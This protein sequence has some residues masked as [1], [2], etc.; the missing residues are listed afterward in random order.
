M[1]N[2]LLSE[3]DGTKELESHLES[4]NQDI[5]KLKDREKHKTRIERDAKRQFDVLEHVRCS[6]CIRIW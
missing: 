2:E 6:L 4:L 3:A 1:Y 5:V